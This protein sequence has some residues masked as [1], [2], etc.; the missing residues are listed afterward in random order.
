VGAV[1][2]FFSYYWRC[3]DVE[4]LSVDSYEFVLGYDQRR[5]RSCILLT[6]IPAVANYCPYSVH[7]I[8][9]CHN[10]G[11]HSVCL[12]TL[13]FLCSHRPAPLSI[14]ISL[15]PPT[16]WI[17]SFRAF[18]NSPLNLRSHLGTVKP[19]TN[20]FLV[21]SGPLWCRQ[22]FLHT[23]AHNC[24]TRMLLSDWPL[25]YCITHTMTSL[26]P[27]TITITTTQS[28]TSA[29]STISPFRTQ[30]WVLP[31]LVTCGVVSRFF[32]EYGG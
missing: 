16:F 26:S 18:H 32:G 12:L 1:Q 9:S 17:Q 19:V 31:E 20:S 29:I 2:L 10:F 30:R 21:L 25:W 15:S 8:T 28:T 27:S 22:S 6:P 11:R 4:C 14:H 3:F 23:A 5:W 13:P 24:A 7:D